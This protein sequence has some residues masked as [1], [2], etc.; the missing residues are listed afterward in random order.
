M[1]HV[2]TLSHRGRRRRKNEDCVLA[3][4]LADDALLLAV[5]DGVGG[6][7]AGE[8]ASRDAVRLIEEQMTAPHDGSPGERLAAAIRHANGIVWQRG[9]QAAHLHGMATTVVAGFVQGGRAWL[10]NVGD[11]R[12]YL[13]HK[14]EIVRVTQDH[15]LVAE[16]VREGNLTEEEARQSRV[17]H[18]ITRSVG[19]GAELEVDLFGPLELAPETTL[20]LCSDGLYEV[21]GDG[22]I[23]AAVT[24]ASPV[25]AAHRLVDL[26]NE[27]GGPDNISVV[28][29]RETGRS[30]PGRAR[31]AEGTLDPP[32]RYTIAGITTSSGSWPQVAAAMRHSGVAQVEVAQ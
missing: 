30:E 20:L 26:A 7:R 17:R 27:R 21:V 31:Q 29:Y 16:R 11:S 25:E 32:G 23:L 10:A 24:D 28:V 14:G 9:Q 2:A 6:E 13:I 5:A 22:E 15:S 19:S 1:E 18:I 3:A 8:V 12:A 4:Q